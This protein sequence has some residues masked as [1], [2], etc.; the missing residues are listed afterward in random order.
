[1]EVAR[2]Y[3]LGTEPDERQRLELQHRLWQRRA[4]EAWRRAGLKPGMAALDLGSGPG[5]ASRDLAALVGAGGRVLGLEKDSTYLAAAQAMAKES[6]LPQLAFR[7]HD[8]HQAPLALV[9]AFDLSWCRWVA[10]FLGDLE[11][12]VAQLQL[13]LRPGGAAVFH[14]YIH[15]STFGLYP[16]GAILQRFAAAVLSSFE[17]GGGDANVNRR[18]PALLAARG[19]RIEAVRPLASVGGPGSWVAQWLEPFVQVYGR[20]LQALGLWSAA[21]AA[22]AGAAMDAARRDPGS[23]WVGPTVLEVVARRLE[24]PA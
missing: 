21:E 7:Q 8:L 1:M 23:L 2:S 15:W 24:T 17:A 13:A 3:V 4:L 11:P 5:W 19:F 22:A 9:Q 6:H 20:R 14:E 12:L 18:L 10:M 16:D